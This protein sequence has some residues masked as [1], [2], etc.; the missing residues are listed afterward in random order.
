ML[1]VRVLFLASA[2]A[3]LSGCEPTG[4]SL[5]KR[6]E[7]QDK[8][9]KPDDCTKSGSLQFWQG[10]VGSSQLED[11]WTRCMEEAKARC[12]TPEEKG[13]LRGFACRMHGNAAKDSLVTYR[14]D[15]TAVVQSQGGE[16]KR[17]PY[18][19]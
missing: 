10:D 14:C 16:E 12:N 8:I 1:L 4:V 11:A 9:Y 15:E 5:C 6:G 3:C 18:R 19:E 13:S 7:D 17:I 2:A